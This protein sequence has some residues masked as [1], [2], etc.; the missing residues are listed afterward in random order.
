MALAAANPLVKAPNAKIAYDNKKLQEWIA[1]SRDP[2]YFMENFMWIR[3]PDP[4]KGRMR[5]EAYGYQKQMIDC[6]W[7]FKDSI[8]LLPRQ[9]G[10]TTTAAGFL[11]WY[12]MFN[13]DVHV[14]IAANKFNAAKEIMDRVK[15]TYE[16]LPDHIRAGAKV[17]NVQTIEF[18]N[19]SKIESVTTTADSG[20]GK[21]ISL[22]Y[23][24]E[25]AFVKP[26]IADEFWTSMAPTLATG[27]KCI[28]TSTPNSDEDK[29][30]EIWYGA[31]KTTDEWGNDIENGVGI[32]GFKSFTAHYSEVPGRDEAWAAKES[33]KIGMDRF[34]REYGC[35]FITADSTLI[36]GA[37]LLGM[38]GI[39]PM[40]RTHGHVRWYEQPRP[41]VTYLVAL[42]PSQGV[43]RDDAAIQVFS[44]PDMA[45]VAEWTNNRTPIPQQVRTMQ[46]IV[47]YLHAEIKKNPEQRGDP[48]IYF[49]VE[50]NSYG[51]AA[52]MA[53]NEIGEDAFQGIMMHEPRRPG[54]GR[55]R[56]FS[57][58]PKSK[59]T[60]CI[61]M[62]SLIESD[63]LKL[64]SRL[65]V[66]Q[67]K[68]FVAK[69]DSFAGKS[70][71]H[72]DAVM[73]T[74]LCVRMMMNIQNWDQRFEDAIKDTFED[75]DHHE[76]MP[77]VLA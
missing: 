74:L 51:Q 59:V 35:E 39:E 60:A 54:M 37:K 27:G 64:R 49:T 34:R 40:Y 24:D 22:L 50:N 20:R 33:A 72:D 66:R 77:I 3:H 14:L 23:V 19:G 6:F 46:Q 38:Q 62:K 4:R 76:P 11:L 30:A 12:A 43:G 42:D 41:G 7:K 10:K 48:D 29:F 63:R 68:F 47:N 57:T 70:G 17:Y 31:M 5:F 71:E 45:Q 21:S 58:Q 25:F 55:T 73:S 69:G 32:N 18:E 53:I 36:A 15:F 16:E 2:L 52:L 8:A 75:A 67:L 28:I 61:K 44:M 56:G 9:S 26:R 1:C 13:P 65:L